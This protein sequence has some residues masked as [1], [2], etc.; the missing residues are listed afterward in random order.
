[1]IFVKIK[2]LLVFNFFSWNLSMTF[3]V[4]KGTGIRP[5]VIALLAARKG[6]LKMFLYHIPEFR[7]LTEKDNVYSHW[8][9]KLSKVKRRE[10]C[11]CSRTFRFH[12]FSFSLKKLSKVKRG[13]CLCSWT[14]SAV[15]CIS[16]LPGRTVNV[17]PLQLLG[18]FPQSEE[19]IRENNNLVATL[20]LVK[21]NQKLASSKLV[22]IHDI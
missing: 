9:K 14:F 12:K 20:L 10:V 1:M 13:V 21:S 15:S 2:S 6:N 16:S 4:I 17:W 3:F 8:K 22:R 19:V 7:S 11:L 5:L 18:I